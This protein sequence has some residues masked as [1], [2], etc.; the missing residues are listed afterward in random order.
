MGDE[1]LFDALDVAFTRSIAGSR[2]SATTPVVLFSGGVDSGLLAWELRRQPGL[3]LSTVGT[4][5]SRDLAAAKEGAA[6]VGVPWVPVEVNRCDVR[7]IVERTRSLLSD[8][9]PTSRSVQTA[10]ALAVER[11]PAGDLLCGQGADELF[12]GYAHFQNLSPTAASERST[13]DLDRLLRH[14]WP[15]SQRIAREL[16]RSVV[17]P[18]L[19][20][21]FIEAAQS[22]PIERR[23]PRPTPKDFFRRWASR[24]GLPA[25]IADRPK[26]ALQF[27]SGIDRLLSREVNGRD[28]SGHISK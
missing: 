13:T 24:R 22:V 18:Y 3:Q 8:S 26:R 9:G 12:L 20:A 28:P 15:L 25:A 21:G 6:I 5:G 1:T 23:L 17:A 27:G 2:V 14:D 19:E 11:A 10:F 7:S 4:A 16:G